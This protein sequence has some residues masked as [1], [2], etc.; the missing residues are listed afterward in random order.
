MSKLF[1]IMVRKNNNRGKNNKLKRKNTPDSTSAKNNLYS[2]ARKLKEN[3]LVTIN[4]GTNGALLH[5]IINRKKTRELTEI[6]PGV[7]KGEIGKKK[8]VYVID[9]TD[10]MID[11]PIPDVDK[12]SKIS[13][14][15]SDKSD[16]PGAVISYAM[17]KLERKAKKELVPEFFKNL[18]N[19]ELA[20]VLINYESE[21][22]GIKLSKDDVPIIEDTDSIMFPLTPPKKKEVNKN[23]LDKTKIINLFGTNVQVAYN[24]KKGIGLI[25]QKDVRNYLMTVLQKWE[26]GEIKLDD[27]LKS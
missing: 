25:A 13:V 24:D 20:D 26:K 7:Y 23:E 18:K 8:R 1:L 11:A 14:I 5:D 15:V 27:L 19:K 16:L 22:E 17:E 10:E 2:I 21:H 9:H 12:F 6:Y 3:D 4:I